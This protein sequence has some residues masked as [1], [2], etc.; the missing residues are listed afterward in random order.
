ML[1]VSYDFTDNHIRSR[2]SKFLKKF[3]G[4]IQYSVYEIKNSQ[5]ILQNILDE[6]EL[7]YKKDF[8]GADSIL[9]FSLCEACKKKIVRYGYAKNEESEVII[10]K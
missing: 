3:G 10:F 9:I 1:I 8:T 6:V 7:N 4:K 5:R 2:F